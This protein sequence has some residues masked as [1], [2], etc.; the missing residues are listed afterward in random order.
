MIE[1]L[2]VSKVHNELFTTCKK[3]DV[4]AEI[5][6]AQVF[7]AEDLLT[8]SKHKVNYPKDAEYW[9]RR[10]DEYAKKI[11]GGF[12][13]VTWEEYEK[14]EREKWLSKELI[15][16][17]EKEYE[18]MLSFAVSIHDDGRFQ[19]YNNRERTSDS[20]TGQ[21][22]YDRKTKKFYFATVDSCDRSTWIPFKFFYLTQG[23]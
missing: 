7:Y 1:M 9:Q 12:E 3:E 15:E 22:C 4:P 16:I 10:I 17:T 2:I 20:F 18:D 6:R 11:A 13:A 8:V 23:G 5:D 19:Y 21:Y 14:R